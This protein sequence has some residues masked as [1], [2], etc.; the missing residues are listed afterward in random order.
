MRLWIRFATILVT[1]LSL[2]GCASSGGT[3]GQ[4]GRQ[5]TITREE[6]TATGLSNM[7][8][9]I[10][11]L[12]PHYLRG[13]GQSTISGGADRVSVYVDNAQLG[14]PET[15]RSVIASSVA[16]VEFV[17]GPDTAYRFGMNHPA[18]VI[19]ILTR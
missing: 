17:T 10:T 1:T 6:I 15:L 7:E 12:R 14:G 3:G 5:N 9:V 18:G 11:Q 19:H 4:V 13:R 2:A 16:R 8:D